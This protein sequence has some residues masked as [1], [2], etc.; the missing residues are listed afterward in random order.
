MFFSANVL[1]MVSFI[2]GNLSSLS[3]TFK[4]QQ[5][6]YVLVSFQFLAYQ[7]SLPLVVDPCKE[8]RLC[9]LFPSNIFLSR[10]YPPFLSPF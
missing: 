3:K 9:L 2:E 4:A 5:M 7:M 6:K 10:R 1:L 8:S